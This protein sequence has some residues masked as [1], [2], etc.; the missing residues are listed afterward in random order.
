LCPRTWCSELLR[1]DTKK[2]GRFEGIGHRFAGRRPG[3][4]RSRGSGWD[5]LHVCVGDASRLAY[6]E[7]LRKASAIAF[8]QRALAWFARHGLTAE[9]IMTDNGSAYQSHDFRYACAA[10]GRRHLRTRPYTPRINGKAER[11]IQTVLRECA[12]ARPFIPSQERNE[13]LAP[14]TVTYSR[15][16]PHGALA[17]QPPISRLRREQPAC[18]RRLAAARGRAFLS[19]LACGGS[20]LRPRI[21]APSR[22]CL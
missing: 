6:T 11:F 8:L 19:P 1:I 2:L 20:V 15:L 10:V 12:Y 18:Q 5:F 17:N 4:H 3:M 22:P 9:R 16:R 13:A 14:W 21:C 7:L